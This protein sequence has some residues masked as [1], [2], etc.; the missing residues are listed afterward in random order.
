MRAHDLEQSG[1]DLGSP[2]ALYRRHRNLSIA[3]T[4]NFRL[5]LWLSNNSRRSS[6]L[7]PSD[8]QTVSHVSLDPQWC[9][10]LSAPLTRLLYVVSFV[11]GHSLAFNE[12]S[13][14]LLPGGVVVVIT[15]PIQQLLLRRSPLLT[16]RHVPWVDV[17]HRGSGGARISAATAY[18]SAHIR[19]FVLV[20]NRGRRPI[21][22]FS[23]PFPVALVHP[24]RPSAVGRAAT[25]PPLHIVELAAI[26]LSS[27]VIHMSGRSPSRHDVMMT[28]VIRAVSIPLTSSPLTT[29]STL[30]SVPDLYRPLCILSGPVDRCR[31]LAASSVGL[32]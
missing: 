12:R 30:P 7:D 19:S 10:F 14:I 20:A 9:S 8:R 6:V 2:C 17:S 13:S 22:S 28:T 26:K 15:I 32:L 18:S 27:D 21:P 29:R 11:V 23:R 24:R 3:D 16:T 31:S 1:G 4:V 25:Q 5:P